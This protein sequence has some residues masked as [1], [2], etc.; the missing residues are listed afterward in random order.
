MIGG[1]FS[2]EYHLCL[3]TTSRFCGWISPRMERGSLMCCL[4]RARL[5]TLAD[6]RIVGL[7]GIYS[8]LRGNSDR[9]QRKTF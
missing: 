6:L 3:V 7:T 1:D 2:Q 5:A 4:G 9:H 8:A